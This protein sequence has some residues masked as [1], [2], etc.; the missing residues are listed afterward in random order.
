MR[1]IQIAARSLS[2]VSL[3]LVALALSNPFSTLAADPASSPTRSAPPSAGADASRVRTIDWSELLPTD[4][5]G[6]RPPAAPAG[7]DY[8]GDEDSL[9]A[10]SGS[11]RT[12]GKLDGVRIRIP[13]YVVPLSASKGLIDELLLVPYFGACIHV[14]PPPPN[15]V[16]H[17]KLGKGVRFSSLIEEAQWVTGTLHIATK[18]TSM[19][20]TAYTLAGESMEPYRR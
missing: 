16:I 9:V 20:S 12:N 5:R 4:E 11:F 15:Q 14:P 2:P 7:H 10:Q 1:K 19:A 8:F 3:A 18:Q 17:V 6:R 13:G